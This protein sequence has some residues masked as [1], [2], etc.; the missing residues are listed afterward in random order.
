M[1]EQKWIKFMP[2][3]YVI[4]DGVNDGG[5]ILVSQMM[6]LHRNEVTEIKHLKLTRFFFYTQSNNENSFSN[7]LIIIIILNTGKITFT[8]CNTQ[9]K[10]QEFW[11]RFLFV[12]RVVA[13]TKYKWYWI[14]HGKWKMWIVSIGFD[15]NVRMWKSEFAVGKCIHKHTYYYSFYLSLAHTQPLTRRRNEFT[16]WLYNKSIKR[17]ARKRTKKKKLNI[18][19]LKMQKWI[20]HF[21]KQTIIIMAIFF[22]PINKIEID[23]I[24][25]ANKLLLFCVSFVIFTTLFLM[26]L[27]YDRLNDWMT[28]IEFLVWWARSCMCVSDL[29]FVFDKYQIYG[30]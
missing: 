1:N 25:Q 19:R 15:T 8:L 17:Q 4:C 11:R 27:I 6:S 2:F 22:S 16:I 3:V 28:K 13:H 12:Y 7:R 23:S 9:N 14:S 29:L 26:R 18:M 20:A 21:T 30:N 24:D 5:L 10:C